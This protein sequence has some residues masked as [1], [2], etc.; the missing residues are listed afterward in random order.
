MHGLTSLPFDKGND[1]AT[2]R[3]VSL[4]LVEEVAEAASAFV[5]LLTDAKGT[6]GYKRA[7]A[8]GLVKR[9]FSIIEGRRLGHKTSKTHQYYG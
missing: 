1:I 9:A 3:A 7:L 2:G 4:D 6:E 5:E 8:R